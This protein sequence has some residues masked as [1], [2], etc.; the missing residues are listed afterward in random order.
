[1][2]VVTEIPRYAAISY[3]YKRSG[4]LDVLVKGFPTWD[5]FHLGDTQ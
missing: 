2:M 1:M 5:W 3:F 4:H